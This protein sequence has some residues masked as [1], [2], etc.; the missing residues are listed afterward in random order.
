MPRAPSSTCRASVVADPRLTSPY[1]LRSRHRRTLANPP[2]LEQPSFAGSHGQPIVIDNQAPVAP[3]AELPAFINIPAPPGLG[4][5]MFRPQTPCPGLDS[6]VFRPETRALPILT[7]QSS[8]PTSRALLSTSSPHPFIS[9]VALI[10]RCRMG[11][12]PSLVIRVLS[13]STKP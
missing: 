10:L 7:P 5:P 1:P 2:T 11:T 9:L 3:P 8:L 4:S 13:W 12:A 6:P